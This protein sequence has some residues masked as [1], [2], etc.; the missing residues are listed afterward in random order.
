MQITKISF[1]LTVKDANDNYKKCH[2][3]AD[4][5]PGDDFAAVKKELTAEVEKLVSGGAAPSKTAASKPAARTAGTAAAEKTPAKKP[6]DKP[7]PSRRSPRTATPAAKRKTTPYDRDVKAHKTHLKNLLNEHFDGW[8][9]EG[10]ELNELAKA[11]SAGLV[12]VDLLDANGNVL[13][14]FIEA[15]SELMGGSDDA[16]L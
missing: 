15:L 6:A 10:S 8:Q 16:G 11:A 5:H 4:V 3:E 13:D 7:A 9:D 12:G 14:G 1:G 2:L